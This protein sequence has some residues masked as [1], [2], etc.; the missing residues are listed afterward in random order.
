MN[1]HC[2]SPSR[3]AIAFLT[4][5]T[6]VWLSGPLHVDSILVRVFDPELGVNTL[7]P[8]DVIRWRSEGW[9]ETRIGPHGL[10]GWRPKHPDRQSD[11]NRRRVVIWGDS[12]VE[13][14]CLPD[15]MK[16]HN[17]AIR[18]AA[19]DHALALD[20]LPLGRSG[21]DA[22]D[23]QDLTAAADSLWRPDLHVWVVTELSDL[24]ALAA[25]EETT[26]YRRWT[27]GSPGWVK[28]AAALRAEAAFAAAKRLFYDP[29]TGGRRRLDFSLGPRPRSVGV[30][31]TTAESV[32]EPEYEAGVA[33]GTA[34]DREPFDD[35]FAL[36][37][38][39]VV[40]EVESVANELGGRLA[41]VYAPAVPSLG[42]GVDS[43]DRDAVAF[44][45]LRGRLVAAG[46]AVVDVRDDFRAL[47]D[48]ETEFP[49][50][51]HNGMPAAG[52][53]NEAG[54]RL[55]ARSIVSLVRERLER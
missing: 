9:A 4:T 26:P 23:W 12:Q 32:A 33:G 10:P 22:R 18:L 41:L 51:F 36:V 6:L 37:V 34:S 5:W 50:G 31:P 52:H 55:V 27:A 20:C 43:G 7:R 2:I 29:E 15:P 24:T 40:S 39:Q 1:P 13:G 30:P 42:A 25:A 49:R 14:V 46:I 19:D 47:W 28:F 44:A 8:G 48:Q 53:L 11:P 21:A 38:D 35:R 17:Q 54:N 16:I 3:W 45:R